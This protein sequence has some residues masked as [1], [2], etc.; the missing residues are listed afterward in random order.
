[1]NYEDIKLGNIVKFIGGEDSW[2]NAEYDKS[3]EYT[4]TL[5]KYG[6][7]GLI[8]EYM[9]QHDTTPC[10]LIGEFELVR[11]AISQVREFKPNDVVRYIGILESSHYL[12]IDKLY[13]V[14]YSEMYEGALYVADDICA[15]NYLISKNP[16]MFTLVYRENV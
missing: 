15:Q 14:N 4:F 2:C 6:D 5:N 1:M 12:N 16:E 10:V 7:L 3:K 13:V 11:T 8:C 9:N